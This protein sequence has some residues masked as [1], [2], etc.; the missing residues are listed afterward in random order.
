M[1]LPCRYSQ[2]KKNAGTYQA[3]W[4]GDTLRKPPLLCPTESQE[5]D[6]K[7]LGNQWNSNHHDMERIGHNNFSLKRK[8][9][10]QSE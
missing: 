4:C 10:N 6:E 8:E 9:Y 7:S 5:E 3:C 2:L 1:R